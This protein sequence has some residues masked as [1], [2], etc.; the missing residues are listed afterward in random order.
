MV[1]AGSFRM[2]ALMVVMASSLTLL[3]AG[4]VSSTAPEEALS[5]GLTTRAFGRDSLG[6]VRIGFRVSNAGNTTVY[7]NRCG[8]EV[9]ADIE[10]RDAPEQWALTSSAITSCASSLYLGPYRLDPGQTV[11]ATQTARL[12][13]GEFRLRVLVS[14]D[15]DGPP[16]R[17]TTSDVIS[18]F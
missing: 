12:T 16:T 10:R 5:V 18:I 7:L 8:V 6:F 17:S 11:Q 15:A 4:C 14:L 3:L 13:V 1:K 9:A 2:R